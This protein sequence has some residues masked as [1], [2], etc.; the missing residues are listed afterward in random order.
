MRMIMQSNASRK[1]LL[2]LISGR[3][4]RYLAAFPHLSMLAKTLRNAY[5]PVLSFMIMFAIVFLGCGQAFH[6]AFGS[7]L[8]NYASLSRSAM[9]LFR[10]L[11]GEFEYHLRYSNPVWSAFYFC[12]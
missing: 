7:H 1:A 2:L 9:S 8:Q 10:A 6:L 3:A 12:N 11:L 5:Y 4:A